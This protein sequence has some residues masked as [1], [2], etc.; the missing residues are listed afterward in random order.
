MAAAAAVAAF[1]VR[2]KEREKNRTRILIRT[3]GPNCWRLYGKKEK[4]SQG[5]VSLALPSFEVV[6]NKFFSHRKSPMN[7]RTEKKES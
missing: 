5:T 4:G 6:A 2:Q 1:R 3:L 7:G